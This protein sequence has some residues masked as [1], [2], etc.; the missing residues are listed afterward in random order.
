MRLRSSDAAAAERA[1]ILLRIDDMMEARLV[2][3]DAL[4]SEV[5]AAEQAR[6][7][8]SE[9]RRASGNRRVATNTRT[10]RWSKSGAQPNPMETD[11]W[12]R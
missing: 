1:E 8:Q 3:T 12:R 4:V 7:T 11:E 2:L 10:L 5:A 9:R 6:R